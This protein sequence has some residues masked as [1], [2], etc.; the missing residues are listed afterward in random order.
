MK[1]AI[2]GFG[3]RGS[4][5]AGLFQEIGAELTAVCEIRPDR[6][7][8]AG[9]LYELPKDKLFLSDEVFV[10]KGKLGDL[11]VVATQDGQHK[12]HAL[13][14]LDAGYDLLL[15]K[16]IAT[17]FED[18]SA[19]FE[20]AKATGRRVFIC[21]VLRYAPFFTL[22]K[23]ELNTGAYGKIAT[24][25]LTENIAYWHFAHSFTRGNWSVVPPSAPIILAKTCHD[26][27]II[28]WLA[29]AECKAVSSMGSLGFY[30]RESAP[31]G[32]ADRCLD[33]S[34]KMDCP[35]DAERFYITDGFDKGRT[36]WPIDTLCEEPTREKLSEALKTGPYGRCV[37][38]CGN[39]SA[40]RQV[41]NMG[42]AGGM[43]AHLTA[44]AF[45]KD[46]YREIHVHCEKGEIFG[47]MADDILTCN[48]Y[49]GVSKKID[50]RQHAAN[51]LAGHGGGDALL[52]KDIAAIYGGGRGASLTSI[53]N[54]MQSHAIGFAAEA[55]RKTGGMLM[56]VPVF[57]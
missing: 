29:G 25:N 40:D 48:I 9:R 36:G 53:E 46:C 3:A 35:Y 7:G 41:V 37:W 18:C 13:M 56:P 2:L 17:T 33:C 27:D 4:L 26:L 44:T 10:S 47:S 49:G 57:K 5:Y 43:T 34:V 8:K 24:V 15:E 51:G 32:S 22:I 16:P 30:T 54:S 55:S 11:C 6:L 31:L 14:A 38:K 1:Y 21:H 12:G 45:S 52:V 19:I 39:N 20:R 28:C 50:V 42:F 23:Q